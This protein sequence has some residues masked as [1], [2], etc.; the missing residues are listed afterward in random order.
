MSITTRDASATLWRTLLVGLFALVLVALAWLAWFIRAPIPRLDGTLPVNGPSAPITIRRDDRGIPHIEANTSDDALFG[1]GFACAQDRLWQM[2]TLRRRAE[3]RL[4]EIVGPATLERDRYMRQLG[5]TEAAQ[6]DLD[7]LDPRSRAALQAYADGVNAA[8]ASH[9]LPIEFKMLGYQWEP[10][11]PVDT[12]A[13][14]KLMAQNL[15]D[16]WFYLDIKASLVDKFGLPAASAF[17]DMQMPKLERY[18][19]GYA[20]SGKKSAVAQEPS[21]ASYHLALGDDPTGHVRGTGS[22]NWMVSPSRTSTGKPVL[23]NDTHLDR[24][25]PSTWWTADL[26]GG[27]LHVAGFTVPGI[28]GIV[29][30]HNE[31]IA[32]GVTS[33]EE[34][35]QDLYIERFRSATSNEYLANGTWRTAQH[36]I[37]HIGVKGKPDV[38]LDVLVTRHGPVI[39]REGT[40]GLA[41]AWTIL[42]GGGASQALFGVDIAKNFAQFRAALSH[43]VGPVLS[44]GYADTAGNI[45]YQDSGAVPL[46]AAGDGSLPVEGQDDKY[47]WRGIVPFDELPHALN[48]PGGFIVTAN[49]ALVPTSYRPTLSTYFEPPFRAYRIATDLSSMR[50]ASAQTI[51]AIQADIFDYPRWRLAHETARLLASS[52]D[53]QMRALAAELSAWDGTM[54]KD[55]RIPTFVVLEEN[56]VGQELF[57]TRFGTQLYAQYDKHY[58]KIVPILRIL[59]GDRRLDKTGLTKMRVEEAL[60]AAARDVSG[61]KG[62]AGV[63][64][65]ERW[66]A[67]NAA[68]YEHPLSSARWFLGFLSIRPLHE[69]GSTFSVYSN[70]PTHGPVQRLVVDLADLDNSSML[71]PLGQS[72]IYSDPHYDDQLDDFTAVRWAPTPFSQDAVLAATQHTLILNPK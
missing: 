70:R 43:Q 3:G 6:A 60:V 22:N 61:G 26:H 64:G 40:R 4:S 57:G 50:G 32:F 14:V 72:G 20:P 62:L 66:G 65:L 53:A 17:V 52:P 27:D 21:P 5:L 13:I 49:Q 54:V 23:S 55:S 48:P 36:R 19:P 56:R 31:R 67:H 30:G 29:V 59:D 18:I 24:S 9:R 41:L 28:P 71:L 12:L 51:G 46:R 16:Q 7:G 10:W 37:E 1:E 68:I 69:P 8:A 33:A 35:V 63:T 25:L 45:G 38:I 34:A 15:D 39:R 42:Q 47:A 58:W 2:D 11:R 44:F